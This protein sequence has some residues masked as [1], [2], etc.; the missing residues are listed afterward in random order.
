[1]AFCVH[2]LEE[3]IERY[4]TSKNFNTDEES[5]F[6]CAKHISELEK[7]RIKISMDEAANIPL[8][9][10]PDEILYF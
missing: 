6:T 8:D 7:D 10:R 5:Q 3:T 4:D 1:V 9:F 2:A